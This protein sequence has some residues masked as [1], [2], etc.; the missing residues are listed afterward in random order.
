MKKYFY[1]QSY[2]AFNLALFMNLDDDVIVISAAKN[3]IKA[4]DFLKVKYIEHSPFANRDFVKRK[5]KIKSEVDR[6]IR[7]I[8]NDELHFSHTQF[9]VFCFYLVKKLN[10]RSGKTV[11]HNFE[12]LYSSPNKLSLFKRNFYRVKS[13]QVIIAIIYKLPIVVRMSSST[14]F[15]ISFDINYI[16]DYCNEV[17]DDKKQ[18]YDLTI[19]MFQNY[20]FDYP[21]IG[22]LF[23]AQTFTNQAFFDTKKVET[24][25]PILNTSNVSVKNHPKLGPVAG[26]TNCDE[27]PEFLPVELFF[28]KVT[29]SVISFQSASLIT[30][31]CFK[32]IK[33]ISLLD[34]VK[35]DDIFNEKVKKNLISQSE[36]RI[37][38][39]Q[40]IA[41]FIKL[42]DQ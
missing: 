40:S 30:A 35:T 31:S 15:M 25:L 4:C 13:W 8:G 6:L 11:F 20:S 32:N 42:I 29:G 41:E 5:Y 27:L 10:D 34:L 24:L 36:N 16:N 2:Q 22:N 19:K 18:Y 28:Q 38:F 1:C 39:P 26:L 14:S 3:I 7:E 17:I 33:V 23:I 21:N 12:F 37:V 9:A